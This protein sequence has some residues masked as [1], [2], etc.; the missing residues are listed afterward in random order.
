MTVIFT[1]LMVLAISWTMSNREFYF[2]TLQMSVFFVAESQKIKRFSGVVS[3]KIKIKLLN[4]VLVI[5]WCIGDLT[6][7]KMCLDAVVA[8]VLLANSLMHRFLQ[9][10]IFNATKITVKKLQIN[11]KK[12]I[13]HTLSSLYIYASSTHMTT[14]NSLF[15]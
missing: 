15:F 11:P 10:F 8:M 13:Q 5:L 4:H 7:H 12:K 1:L 3:F 2:S 6:K 14:Y 9:L